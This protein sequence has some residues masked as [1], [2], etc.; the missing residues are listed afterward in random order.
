MKDTFKLP[1]TSKVLTS[2]RKTTKSHCD[3]KYTTIEL[4]GI[5]QCMCLNIQ[6]NT[7]MESN[8]LKCT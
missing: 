1:K 5:L 8:V 2:Q 7:L 6:L 4:Y 3:L